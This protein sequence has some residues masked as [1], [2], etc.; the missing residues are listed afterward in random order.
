MTPAISNLVRTGRTHQ[1][2]SALAAGAAHG[3]Q[4]MDQ[5]LAELVLE[6]AITPD[7]AMQVA[8]DKEILGRLLR[9]FFT[10][11]ADAGQ[12]RSA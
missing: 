2:P 3:M 6:G 7:A 12:K 4:S 11:W 9:G 5:R 10:D 8:H 1:I